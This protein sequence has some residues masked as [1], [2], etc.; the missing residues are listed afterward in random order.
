MIN[1]VAID[2]E[3]LALVVL[4]DYISRTP[5]LVLKQSFTDA[6]A[7]IE[8]LKSHEIELMFL[9]IRMPRITGI[10]LLK[11]LPKPPLVIFTTAYSNYAV[12]GFN[13]DAVDFLLKPFEYERFLK[14][15]NKTSEY[16]HY[17]QKAIVNENAEYIFVKSEYQ[18]IKFNL[19]DIRY[20]EGMDDY[21]KIYRSE[22]MVLTNM[23]MKDILKKLPENRFARVHRSFIV[24]LKRIESVRNKR[25]KIDDKLIPIGDSY[26]DAFFK[27]LGEN[28]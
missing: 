6:F 7:A 21:V 3:P 9:D 15:V 10:Q 26:A 22:K 16:L 4:Q 25:I 23:P 27:L 14:A 24:S 2:D 28:G 12:D 5:Q 1:C 11:S 8:Y 20:I 13:L 17:N 19:D 18:I